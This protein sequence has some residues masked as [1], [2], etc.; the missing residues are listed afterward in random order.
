[1]KTADLKALNDLNDL[2]NNLYVKFA[3][4]VI[5][6]VLAIWLIE[7]QT[8]DVEQKQLMKKLDLNELINVEFS[9]SAN[10]K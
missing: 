10:L 4:N 1:M 2:I 6:E 3:S 9:W 5:C 7:N 8:R